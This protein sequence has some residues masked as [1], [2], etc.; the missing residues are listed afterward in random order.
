MTKRILILLMFALS[1]SGCLGAKQQSPAIVYYT[2]AY[3]PPAFTSLAPLPAVI[4]V[5]RFQVS[6]LYNSTKIVFQENQFERDAYNYH[7]WR[8]NPGEIVA[9]FL[10]R[11]MEQSSLFKAVFV[12]DRRFPASHLIQG[13]VEEFHEL[14]SANS[15]HAALSLSVTL[16]AAGEPDVSKSIVFQKRYPVKIPCREKTLKALVESMSS[17][18]R[19]V[20]EKIILDVYQTLARSPGIPGRISSRGLP[21][22]AGLSPPLRL[23][24]QNRAM[25]QRGEKI[26]QINDDV[27]YRTLKANGGDYIRKGKLKALVFNGK[28]YD[29]FSIEV[30]RGAVLII[31]TPDGTFSLDIVD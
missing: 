20:S 3:D 13:L 23:I 6:P 26:I 8:A 5:Q 15:W 2:L 29:D 14:D 30:V 1:V 11:D 9:Y 25:K 12:F 16:V 10:A 31:T 18:M 7:K 28:M 4:Q 24:A 22:P 21:E 27:I 19:H 17:A